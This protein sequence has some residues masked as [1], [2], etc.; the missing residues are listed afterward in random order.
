MANRNLTW[1]EHRG[2]NEL[3]AR[4]QTKLSLL[5]NG[6][7]RNLKIEKK[8][9]DYKFGNRNYLVPRNGFKS[10]YE[11][12]LK[13][14]YLKFAEFLKEHGLDNDGRRNYDEYDIRTLIFI[15]ENKNEFS[16]KLT[17]IRQFSALVFKEKGS[18]YLENK[19]S[20]KRAVCRL[21]QIDHFP[22]ED[23]K[24]NQWRLVVDCLQPKAVILCENIAHLKNAD[25]M[26]SNNIELWY[27]GGN[28]V[29]IIKF[30][31]PEKL[32]L[33][34]YYS[35]DWDL[36]GLQIYLRVKT[37]IEEK[38]AKIKL[39]YPHIMQTSLPVDSPYHFSKWDAA[40]P[41]S[42]LPETEFCEREIMLIQTLIEKKHWIEEESLDLIEIFSFTHL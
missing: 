41:L 13:D 20:V 30:I 28:N 16:Q 34:L 23:P 18:K 9:I 8:L 33:P 29:G 17:T 37:K 6:Y 25:K 40:K 38:G 7:I 2:L 24:D 4:G 15:S 22:E 5:G 10:F 26:R 19:E 14:V 31:S 42:G 35:C 21:L 32:N 11:Q 12:N 3:Y 39:L 27:V 1:A 36:A